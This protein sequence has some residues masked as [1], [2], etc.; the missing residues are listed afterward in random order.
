[1]SGHIST[2]GQDPDPAGWNSAASAEPSG[3]GTI[4]S[5]S[6]TSAARATPGRA[7]A[8]AT[9]EMVRTADRRVSYKV[10]LGSRTILNLSKFRSANEF[11]RRTYEVRPAGGGPAGLGTDLLSGTTAQIRAA[12]GLSS[13]SS[14]LHSRR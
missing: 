11:L 12:Q 10:D 6:V 8:A 14:S 1:M 4:T 7:A 13:P 9:E 3:V 5:V 2:A